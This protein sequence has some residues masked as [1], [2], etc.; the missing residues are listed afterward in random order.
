MDK[1]Q[2]I[3]IKKIKH[4]MSGTPTYRDWKNMKAR[5]KKNGQTMDPMWEN[6]A[7]F[8]REMGLKGDASGIWAYDETKPYCK[9]NCYWKSWR[10]K[11]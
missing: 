9:D 6:F 8:Y 11:S 7:V 1:S 3:A 10:G 4:G 2:K 5:L